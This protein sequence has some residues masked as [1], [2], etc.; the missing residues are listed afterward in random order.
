MFDDHDLQSS[1]T[2]V[3]PPG[4]PQIAE[5]DFEVEW[6]GVLDRARVRNTQMNFEGQFLQTG[7]TIR[8][9]ALNPTSGFR[10]FSEPP[11]PAR[12]VNAVIGHERN[13]VFFR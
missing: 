2:Q 11:N 13:G 12:A 6:S 8:W 10:F 4:F 5:V 9:S 3:F 7:S 1:L